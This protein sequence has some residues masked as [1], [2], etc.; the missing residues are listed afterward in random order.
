MR[1]SSSFEL[2]AYIPLV[3]HEISNERWNKFLVISILERRNHEIA[4]QQA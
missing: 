3:I 4:E 1:V 2:P